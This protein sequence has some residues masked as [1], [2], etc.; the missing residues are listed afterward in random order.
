MGSFGAWFL[1]L[2][3]ILF[4]LIV[5][6]GGAYLFLPILLAA[7]MT[8]FRIDRDKRRP[9]YP[10]LIVLPAISVLAILWGLVFYFDPAPGRPAHPP[11]V[12]LTLLF[13]PWL[14][15]LFGTLF[16]LRLRGARVF[17]LLYSLVN[18]YAVVIITF[19][20]LMSVTGSW[21]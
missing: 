8:F 5:E 15:L 6:S 14:V 20:A 7:A 12:G 9:T 19:V 4:G 10:L 16:T 11:W 17:A 18:L 1:S 21:L 13:T 3:A 2:Q